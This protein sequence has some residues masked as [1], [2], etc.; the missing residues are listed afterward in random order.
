MMSLVMVIN[1]FTTLTSTNL[2]LTNHLSHLHVDFS[3]WS[4]N[5][6]DKCPTTS[7]FLESF[8]Q[9]CLEFLGH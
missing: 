3:R 6:G 5:L 2:S 4:F 7:S 9:H 1:S 8:Q